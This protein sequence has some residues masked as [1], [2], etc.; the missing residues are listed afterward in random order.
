MQKKA[1][2]THGT[3][4]H[5]LDSRRKIAFGKTCFSIVS[6]E[7]CHKDERFYYSDI[8]A[9]NYCHT[10]VNWF[11]S[12]VKF[13]LLLFFESYGNPVSGESKKLEII[14][15][16]GTK[17]FLFL[18]HTHKDVIESLRKELFTRVSG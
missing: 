7:G 2:Q 11:K 18:E 15:K 4:E 14:F 10:K 8:K 1:K 13:I 12:A 9:V 5:V 16:S 3:T 17:R 6:S